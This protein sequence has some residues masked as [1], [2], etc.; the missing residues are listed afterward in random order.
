M[1]V[2]QRIEELFKESR[3]AAVIDRERADLFAWLVKQPAWL[4]YLEILESKIQGLAD[5][6]LAPAKSVDGMVTL[7]YVKGAMSGL[8][9]ARDIPSITIAA[10]AELG[11]VKEDDDDNVEPV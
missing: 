11:P 4:A 8:I 5:E 7:E 2:D 1:R 3:K 10:K 9:M 6:V